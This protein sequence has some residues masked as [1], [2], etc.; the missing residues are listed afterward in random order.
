MSEVMTKKQ[1]ESSEIQTGA[2]RFCGQIYQFETDGLA[3]EE[4]LDAW[5]TEKCDCVDAKIEQKYTKKADEAKAN[6]ME[7]LEESG[8][9]P[10]QTQVETDLMCQGIDLL[11]RQKIVSMAVVT[12]RGYKLSAKINEKGNLK[13]EISKTIKRSKEA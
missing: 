13:T 1:L 4:Q 12:R 3:T 8:G 6:I 2:C 5:A 9:A 7:M 11:A 10:D